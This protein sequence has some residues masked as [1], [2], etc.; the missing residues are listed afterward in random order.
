MTRGPEE[1]SRVLR[2]SKIR[3]GTV[4]DHIDAGRALHVLKILGLTGGEGLVIAV[5]MNVES[6]KLGRKDIVKVEGLELAEEQVNKISLIAPSATI[7]IIRDYE[8]AEKIQV[9]PPR[10]VVGLLKCINPNCVSRL[11]MEPI[12]SAFTLVSVRP[13]RLEC[14]YCGSRLG[15]E[16]VIAQLTE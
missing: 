13:L 6:R 9:K 11:E 7:N 8:V 1:P 14:N 2:V 16:D 3:Y 4:I 10:E 5:V 15:Q 12:T